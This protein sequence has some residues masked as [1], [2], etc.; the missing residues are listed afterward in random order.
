[1]G[2][3]QA[4]VRREVSDFENFMLNQMIAG[5]ARKPLAAKTR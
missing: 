1:M 3:D 2:W 5:E 4:A